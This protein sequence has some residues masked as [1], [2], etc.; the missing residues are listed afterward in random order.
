MKFKVIKPLIYSGRLYN[1]GEEVDILESEVIKRVKTLGLIETEKNI[2]E[3][4][5]ATDEKTDKK[6]KNKKV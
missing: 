6:T 5:N 4:E 1:T 3:I 2:E